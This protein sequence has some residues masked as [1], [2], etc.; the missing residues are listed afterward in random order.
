MGYRLQAGTGRLGWNRTPRLEP[1]AS[2]RRPYLLRGWG[3]DEVEVGG[4]E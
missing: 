3:L 4:G 2:A 1:D